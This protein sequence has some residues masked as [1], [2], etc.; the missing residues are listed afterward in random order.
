[1]RDAPHTVMR[2]AMPNAV[3]RRIPVLAGLALLGGLLSC[4]REVTGPNGRGPMATLAFDPTMPS[5]RLLGNGEVLGLGDVVPFERVRVVLRRANGEVAGEQMVAFAAGQQTVTVAITVQLGAGASSTGEALSATM[6]YINAAGDTV[7]SGGPLEVIAR[8]ASSGNPPP[9]VQLPITYVGPGSDAAGISISPDSVVG[10]INQQA[11]FSAIVV[12]AGQTPIPNAPVAYSS[13]DSARVRVNVA[14]G[15]ATLVGARGTA[16]IIAQTANDRADTALVRITPTPSAIVL[17]SGGNQQTLQGTPF[18]NPVRVRV[19]A[20]DGLGVPGVTVNFAVTRGQGS[21]S[22]PSAVTDAAGE[23]Q[24]SWI[25]GDSAG[26]AILTASVATPVL[27]LPVAGQQISSAPTSLTFSGSPANFTAGD[28][29]PPFSVSV[30]DGTGAVVNGFSGNVALSLTGGTA[31][32]SIIGGATR[33]AVNGVATFPGLT[34]DRGGTGYRIVATVSGVPPVSTNTFDVAAAPPRFVNVLSG[35]GQTAPPSTPLPDSVRVRVTDVFG[36]PQPGLTVQFAVAAGGGAVSPASVTTNADGRAATQWTLGA[37]GAQQITVTVGSIQPVPVNATLFTGGGT[38]TLFIGT[39]Q[40]SATIGST[41]SVPVFITPPPGTAVV[42]QLVTRD[43]LVAKWTVDSTIFGAGVGLRSPTLSGRGVGSTYAVVSSS[44][45]NDSVLVTVD[46]VGI[47]FGSYSGRSALVG[48]TMPFLVRLSAPAGQ[49]GATVVVRSPDTLALRVATGSGRTPPNSP[50]DLYCYDLKAT[51]DEVT[52]LSTPGDS[53]VVTIPEGQLSGYV[54][55]LPVG[56]SANGITVTATAPQMAS[57][58][59]TLYI[60]PAQLYLYEYF[61]V[62][63]N[64]AMP[65]GHRNGAEVYVYYSVAR[66]VRVRITSRNP[67]VVRADSAVV[68]PSSSYYYGEV[69]RF[70]YEGLQPGSTWIVVS[71]PGFAT[72]S[73]P[74]TVVAPWLVI[75][76]SNPV[77]AVGSDYDLLVYG[78]IDSVTT[79]SYA[80][81]PRGSP[82]SVGASSSDPTVARVIETGPIGTDRHDTQVRVRGLAAGTAWIRTTAPGYAADSVLV[83]VQGATL[84]VQEPYFRIGRGQYHESMRLQLLGG[85]NIVTTGQTATVTSSDTS[86]L[87]VLTPELPFATNGSSP[88]VRL[89][90]K[91]VGSA[92]I[93][94]TVPGITP[95]VRAWT[96]TTPDLFLSTFGGG[97][98]INADSA[99]Y[100]ISVSMRDGV[101]VSRPAADTV[102]AMLRSTNPAVMLVTDS[103]ARFLPGSSSNN[104]ARVRAIGPGTALL[105]LSAPNFRSDTSGLITVQPRRL[106]IS[107]AA[108]QVTGRGLIMPMTVIRR[109]PPTNALPITI[110][111][112]GPAGVVPVAAMDSIRAGSGSWTFALRAGASTGLDTI[113]VS[114]AG[115]A[116]DTLFVSVGTSTAEIFA[117]Y[118]GYVGEQDEFVSASMRPSSIFSYR[119]ASD[120]V[121]FRFVSSD[122]T[123]IR[124]IRDTIRVNAG[125]PV[126]ETGGYGI[127]RY[128]RPGS[129]WLRLID[130]SGFFDTDSQEVFVGLRTLYLGGGSPV[131][132]INQQSN[133]FENYVYRDDPGPDSLW[134]RL[135]SSSPSSV[136]VTDS[137]LIEPFSSYAYY[138][139]VA[140]DSV[141]SARITANAAGF[142]ESR[143]DVYVTRSTVRPYAYY[144][145]TLGV[146]GLAEIDLYLTDLDGY[147]REATVPVPIRLRVDDPS[148]LSAGADSI[149]TFAV[150]ESMVRLQTLRGVAPGRGNVT[151]EDRRGDILQAI[152]PAS[153]PVEVRENE[154]LFGQYGYKVGLGATTQAFNLYF[155]S[156]TIGPARWARVTA[157]AGRVRATTDSVLVDPAQGSFHYFALEGLALGTDTLIVSAPGYAPDTAIVDVGRNLLR[158]ITF[159]PPT[160][161]QGDSVLVTLR[162]QGPDEYS[163]LEPITA[164]MSL[165]FTS[166]GGLQAVAVGGGNLTTTAIPIGASNISFWLR[167]TGPA[168][169]S[170]TVTGPSIQTY[171]LGVATRP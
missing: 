31:G 29:I 126:A 87:A 46:S 113:I 2:P 91:G 118:S 171:Q 25:A 34:I 164:P 47:F 45:G 5:I 150:G 84:Q 15:V 157:A 73:F 78:S 165:T 123:I 134:V 102:F 158:A 168:G 69:A 80:Y 76:Q 133:P 75:S 28:T 58:D 23:A 143:Q 152:I 53:A 163:I 156:S 114:A 71:A 41:R 151:I 83:T 121:R 86:V 4:G 30:R 57:G 39:E 72:D 122:T 18:P 37:A 97:G 88:F 109:S 136:S 139:V 40:I 100:S 117:Q 132:G 96:V 124:V 120:T 17:V 140:G 82:L 160:I 99:S 48:D 67:G 146:D 105:V 35:A 21:V 145:T 170:I 92:N 149:A 153:S 108:T 19:N 59:M 125:A 111:R 103:I 12:T 22:V 7:F 63:L 55:L 131:L 62:P 20:V 9:P 44:A 90:G 66:D 77:L 81:P 116:S 64:S 68:L 14:T 43:S 112:Q 161:R 167:A 142:A 115:H 137:V 32:A 138:T 56:P 79:A 27:S 60:E 42:A 129:A 159:I 1:M 33:A 51:P 24:V 6:K 8:P 54:V 49:G 169:G 147:T 110:T 119:S 162:L 148:I 128:V 104:T 141:G 85:G 10:V 101:N 130:P 50:C 135:A 3:L 98:N 127:V 16:L 70:F 93:T 61:G 155:T 106:E 95:D 74:V 89:L 144:G 26:A 11:T 154:L 38:P 13:T 36:F 94:I 166:G 107:G 65:V 52:I